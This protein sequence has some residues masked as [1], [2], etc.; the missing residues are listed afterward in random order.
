MQRLDTTG[1]VIYVSSLS[2]AI[3][4]ALRLGYAV[5]PPGMMSLYRRCKELSS[6]GSPAHV[7][8]TL[9][10]FIQRGLFERHLRRVRRIYAE[11]RAL[12]VA[13]I[14][15]HLPEMVSHQGSCAGLHLLVWVHRVRAAHWRE[16]LLHASRRQVAVFAATSLF[17]KTPR[18]L[19]LMIAYGGIEAAAI[20]PGIRALAEAIRT[21]SEER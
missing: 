12:L 2:K 18:C 20:E 7:Q 21:W 19:P 9:A 11:R 15:R 16:F 8:K 13:A 5:L 6:G 3:S 14:E 17:A 1:R 4:P 10:H